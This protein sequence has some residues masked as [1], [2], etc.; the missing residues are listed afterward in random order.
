L[1]YSTELRAQILKTGCF[2]RTWIYWPLTKLKGNDMPD[3]KPKK[4]DP[5][6]PLFPHS[7]GQ[8]AKKLN[9]IVHDFGG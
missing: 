3:S 2:L 7:N 4:L 8:W 9:S 5:E 6:F 1:L